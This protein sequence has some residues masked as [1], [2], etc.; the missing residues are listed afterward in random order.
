MDPSVLRHRARSTHLLWRLDPEFDPNAAI[1]E[2]AARLLESRLTHSLAPSN[3]FSAALDAK[4]F[5]E[6]L[7]RRI[8]RVMDALAEGQLTLNVQ[9]IDTLGISKIGYRSSGPSA[10]TRSDSTLFSV[11]YPKNDTVTV[12]FTVPSSIGVGATLATSPSS[13]AT[14]SGRRCSACTLALSSLPGRKP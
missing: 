10:L 13:T 4:E 11:P 14:L 8:N 12:S 1:Q 6:K 2:H 3:L 9:G 5:A 7:P